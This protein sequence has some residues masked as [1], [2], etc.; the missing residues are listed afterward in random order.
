MDRD[1]LSNVLERVRRVPLET[2]W[3]PAEHPYEVLVGAILTQNTNWHNVRLAL[4]RLA[5]P[6]T[7]QSVLS[8]SSEALAQRI[9]P[10]GFYRQKSATLQRATQWYCE[11]AGEAAGPD[12]NLH[13]LRAELLAIRGIGPE[14]ADSILCYGFGLPVLVIDAYTRRILSRCGLVPPRSHDALRREM[15]A[16]V[17]PDAAVLGAL[18]GQL[19]EL[20]KAHCR[21]VPRCAGCVLQPL[22][23]TGKENA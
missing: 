10:S 18:H 15:E 4:S 22:C 11:R 2:R 19:V 3:W 8:L 7:P 6:L 1:H 5:R 12:V 16:L 20:A 21:K 9:R 23:A 14:T 17:E 13:A